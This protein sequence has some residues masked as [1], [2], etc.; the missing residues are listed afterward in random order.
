MFRNNIKLLVVGCVLIVC[1]FCLLQYLLILK[2]YRLEKEKYIAEVRQSVAEHLRGQVENLHIKAVSSVINIVTKQ[3]SFKENISAAIR[4]QIEKDNKWLQS[5]LRQ[6]IN[7]APGLNDAHYSLTYP[8]II[9]WQGNKADTLVSER[10]DQQVEVAGDHI[11]EQSRLVI[12]TGLQSSNI[13]KIDVDGKSRSYTLEISIAQSVDI[14]GWQSQAF[15]RLALYYLSAA[16]LIILIVLVLY[17]IIASLLKQKKI[18]DIKTDFANNIT[19]ELK[20]PLSTAGIIIKTLGIID[21]VKDTEMFQQQLF[22][23]E[24]QHSKITRTVDWVLESA[25]TSTLPVFIEDI[26]ILSLLH[27][28]KCNQV[29]HAPQVSINCNADERILSDKKLLTSIIGNLLDNAIKYSKAGTAIRINYYQI[30]KAY[31]FEVEDQGTTIPPSYR[32]YL[33]DKFY[34]VPEMDK[35]SKAGLGLGLY[36]S[37]KNAAALGGRMSFHPPTHGG[38]CFQLAIPKY[39]A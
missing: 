18:A 23:L 26:H 32:S 20:T 28:I 1:I 17:G 27:D 39:E 37:K 24:K 25:M 15:K 33:F 13:N 22:S 16:G 19:H 10:R 38:N 11:P 30:D 3:T 5:P 21:P 8:Q 31:I 34:R 7:K 6:A 14:S 9:L 12:S 2:T 29:A 35:H 4:A 36:L